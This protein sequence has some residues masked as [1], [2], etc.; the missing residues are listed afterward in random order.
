MVPSP[1]QGDVQLRGQGRRRGG[2]VG[3]LLGTVA[4][5][6]HVLWKADRASALDRGGGLRHRCAQQ[7]SRP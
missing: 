4:S 5:S 7:D 6:A 1:E 2:E 3:F